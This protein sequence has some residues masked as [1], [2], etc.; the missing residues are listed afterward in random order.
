MS[1]VLELMW[2]LRDV[3]DDAGEDSS[4]DDI[5]LK[6][7]TRCPVGGGICNFLCILCILKEGR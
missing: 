7:G 1:L 5:W 4:E 6:G 3:D 2:V